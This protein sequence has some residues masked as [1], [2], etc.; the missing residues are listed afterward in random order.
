MYHLCSLLF[1]FKLYIHFLRIYCFLFCVGFPDY[2]DAFEKRSPTSDILE[3]AQILSNLTDIEDSPARRYPLFDK[4]TSDVI[5]RIHQNFVE[6]SDE[7]VID[8][9]SIPV[10]I[11]SS[12]ITSIP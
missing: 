4:L 7:I 1:Q 9:F 12:I 2:Y 8:K 6:S 5:S 10:S 11:I 3:A